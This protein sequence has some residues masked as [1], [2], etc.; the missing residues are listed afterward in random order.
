MSD[1]GGGNKMKM[2]IAD[3]Q[4]G[5]NRKQTILNIFKISEWRQIR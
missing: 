1:L 5:Q 3:N 4:A 2:A